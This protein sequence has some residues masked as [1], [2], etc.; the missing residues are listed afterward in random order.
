MDV[1]LFN[2]EVQ[3]DI[4]ERI[5]HLSEIHTMPTR[6][7]FRDKDKST[8]RRCAY[9]MIYAE[10]E[11]FFVNTVSIYFREVNK[12][13]LKL[14]DLHQNYYVRDIEKNFRQLKEYPSKQSQ[15]H[16]F[17]KKLQTYFRNLGTVNLKSDVNT[18][19]NLGFEVVNAILENLN[20]QKIPDHID[21]NE[22][23]LKNDLNNFLLRNR[24]GLAHGDPSITVNDTDITSAINLVTRLMN[25]VQSIFS[26]G[27]SNESFRN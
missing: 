21:N 13:G 17:L 6:Y 25:V 2:S 7:P 24:N 18:E 19:S 27:L 11:G 1:S 10:W 14:D 9:P 12:L 22:Y 4:N 26:F 15:K 16:S 5:E 20:L 3:A 8:W 23:S